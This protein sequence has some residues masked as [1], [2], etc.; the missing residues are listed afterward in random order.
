MDILHHDSQLM[1][2]YEL[3]ADGSIGEVLSTIIFPLMDSKTNEPHFPSLGFEVDGPIVHFIL[4]STP[5]G[6]AGALR[7]N[8]PVVTECE[9]HWVVTKVE[10]EVSS[11]ILS[12]TVLD[13]LSFKVTDPDN[14]HSPWDGIY[15]DRWFRHISMTLADRHSSTGQSKFGPDN[16]TAMRVWGV[17]TEIAPSTFNLPGQS[18]PINMG[19]VQKPLWS[20]DNPSLY[21]VSE[22]ALPWD[23]PNNVSQHMAKII[24]VMNQGIRGNTR[25]QRSAEGRGREIVVGQAWVHVRFVKV[26]WSWIVIPLTFLLV[27]GFF[28]FATVVR[29]SKGPTGIGKAPG[30]VHLFDDAGEWRTSR[31]FSPGREP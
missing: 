27:S 15:P 12:E 3:S 20:S 19:P 26:N 25:P 21:A 18:S 7:H 14:P 1:S 10:A 6:F 11:G 29:T 30:L 17:W 28:H 24:K 2:G 8:T 9:V 22:S 16:N 23:T 31:W 5:G 13:T 4:V